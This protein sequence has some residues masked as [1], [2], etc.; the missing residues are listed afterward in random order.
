MFTDQTD[1]KK[2]VVID[3]QTGVAG[4]MFL[5]ALIS[6]GANINKIVSA[7]K[8][9]ENLNYGYTNVEVCIRE[10]R[11]KVFK[12][13]HIE[14]T[15]KAKAEITG[16]ELIKLVEENADTLKLSEKAQRFA[17]K[18]I[19]TLV[20]TEMELHGKSMAQVHLHELGQIDTAAEIVG[21]A[22]ALDDLGLFDAKIYSTPA[23]VGGGTFK[24]SHGII[25]SPAP[26]TLA[27][28]KSK[29]FP[30][31][32][33]P[34][35]AELATP[36]GAAI[37][38][39]VVN[40]V[41]SFYPPIVPL[42]V[43]YGSG[44]KEFKELPNVLR[45]TIG[46]PLGREEMKEEIAVLETNLDDVTGEIV[47]HS[48]D[49]LLRAGAKDVSIIPIF[50]KKNRPGQ[51][52]RVIADKADSNRLT[53][54]MLEETG[55]LGVRILTCER[56]ILNREIHE[57]DLYIKNLKEKVKV[58]VV[59]DGYG[60]V[61]HVKPEYEDLKRIAEKTNMPLREITEATTAKA[62]EIYL[63]K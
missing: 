18:T 3:C 15:A 49:K 52:L 51:I 11:Q 46:Q 34:I 17:S 55:S 12:A 35:E 21:T 53:R 39:N 45:I 59:K 30:I 22:T 36:T 33:G 7:I 40:E 57:M 48:L 47:G 13:T 60:T 23:A 5:G 50:T 16:Q 28:F 10:D 25:A 27:I 32:G 62:R 38:V 6:L 41:C 29:N 26:A 14:V 58:K 24:F 61:V 43:G 37:L 19:R 1:S 42:G 63:K 9:L 31:K 44:T 8:S 54:L 4:D 20:E 56:Q 2:I